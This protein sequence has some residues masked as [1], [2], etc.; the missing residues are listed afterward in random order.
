MLWLWHISHRR[1]ASV[2]LESSLE[3]EIN[4]NIF[5]LF[6]VDSVPSFQLF[7]VMNTFFFHF[8]LDPEVKHRP[9]FSEKPSSLCLVGIQFKTSIFWW[10]A[11]FIFFKWYVWASLKKHISNYKW[12]NWILYYILNVRRPFSQLFERK[13][14]CFLTKCYSFAFLSKC[15]YWRLCLV[16]SLLCFNILGL[17]LKKDH[18]TT[19]ATLWK[20]L[21]RR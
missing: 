20:Q 21:R 14:L 10:D 15:Y 5:I 19:E 13:T 7:S 1:T 2:E 17:T 9:S 18:L 8:I 16:I 6:K 12:A 11:G 4:M 3:Y